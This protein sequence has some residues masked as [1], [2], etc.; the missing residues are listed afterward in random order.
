VILHKKRSA[1]IENNKKSND[2]VGTATLVTADGDLEAAAK[3]EG[4]RVWNCLKEET[5]AEQIG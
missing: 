5:P 2:P 4:L 1:R 3:E